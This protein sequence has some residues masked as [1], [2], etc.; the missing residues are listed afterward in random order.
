MIR[1]PPRSTLFPYTTLFRSRWRGS[2]V[3]VG[4]PR[5]AAPREWG[6]RARARRLVSAV[7]GL[8]PLLS[9]ATAAISGTR[10]AHRDPASVAV[11][12]LSPRVAETP[13]TSPG[14]REGSRETPASS[15]SHCVI[16]ESHEQ[17]RDQRHRV[18]PPS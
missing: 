15:P 9:P 10:G 1:R 3:H 6:T 8:L 5:R 17:Q 11:S 13:P 18:S 12:S 4:G 16:R 2:G 7:P 14:N